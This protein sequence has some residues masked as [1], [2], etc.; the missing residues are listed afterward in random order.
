MLNRFCTHKKSLFGFWVVSAG[1]LGLEVIA[2][3]SQV[4][5]DVSGDVLGEEQLPS[6]KESEA[7]STDIYEAKVQK[8][9]HYPTKNKK[10]MDT[11]GTEA[12]GRFEAETI[13]KSQYKLKGVPLEVDPD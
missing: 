4:S 9:D 3:P 2:A 5:K 13:L 12:P 1:L 6:G 11:E 8:I 7:A 10:P